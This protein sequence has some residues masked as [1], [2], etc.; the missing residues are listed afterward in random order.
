MT[1]RLGR[2]ALGAIARLLAEEATKR[3]RGAALQLSFFSI[4]VFG[5]FFRRDKIAD[6]E[7]NGTQCVSS[8]NLIPLEE[9]NTCN[10]ED[11][12]AAEGE[13]NCKQS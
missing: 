8:R 4:T 9:T 12:P 2:G 1:A 3:G 11:C 10:N 6:A 13:N 5:F 7:N